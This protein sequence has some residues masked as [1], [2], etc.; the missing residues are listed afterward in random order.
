MAYFRAMRAV[1]QR[2]SQ[3]SVTVGGQVV[4]AIGPGLLILL[5]VEEGD[6]LTDLQWLV[7]K[8]ARMRIFNDVHGHMNLSV[9]DV[10]VEAL[11]VSQFTLH[12]STKKGNRPSFIRAARPE[13]AQP[14]YEQFR[15]ALAH[16]IGRPVPGGVFG[17]MMQVELINDGPVT[18]I[19]DS[20][21]CV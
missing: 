13:V 8:V 10:G 16:E 2:V 9:Q 21:N 1:L 18:I 15:L 4:G 3:A 5:G 12:A 14:L 7:G 17:A 20:R 11:V 19:I 6:T